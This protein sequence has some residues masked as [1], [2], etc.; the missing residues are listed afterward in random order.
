[1]DSE[2]EPTTRINITAI[3]REELLFNRVPY[4]I[5]SNVN[6]FKPSFGAA[7]QFRK[8]LTQFIQDNS[9]HN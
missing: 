2:A 9:D 4:N 1:M 6:A 3:N 7:F 5:I 8:L